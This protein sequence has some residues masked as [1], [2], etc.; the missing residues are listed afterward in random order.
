MARASNRK[1]PETEW[2]G[3]V[4]AILAKKH[5]PSLL[6]RC[7]LAIARSSLFLWVRR[8]S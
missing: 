8:I 6:V 4:E 1:K 7:K 5:H 2:N 3:A